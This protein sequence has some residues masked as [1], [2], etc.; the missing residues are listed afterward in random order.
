M[1]I[2]K[3]KKII[4]TSFPICFLHLVLKSY[5]GSA[6]KVVFVRKIQTLNSHDFVKGDLFKTLHRCEQ[7]HIL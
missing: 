6:W 2:S 5:L 4:H 1:S 3:E 7:H